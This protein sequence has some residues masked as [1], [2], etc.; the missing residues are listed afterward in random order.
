MLDKAFSLYHNLW[1]KSNICKF[2]EWFNRSN[3]DLLRGVG[4]NHLAVSI[5][6]WS[7]TVTLNEIFAAYI[8]R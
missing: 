4:D 7:I 8:S 6:A 5:L 2:L 3:G 1:S